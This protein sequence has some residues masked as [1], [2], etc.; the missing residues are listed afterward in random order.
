MARI[1]CTLAVALC[2]TTASAQQWA[3]KMFSEKDVDF[4]AVPRAAKIE[5]D[6]IVTNPYNEEVHIAHVRS[7]CGC[8]QPRIEHDTLKPGEQGKIVAAFNTRA[9]T[10]Q[11]GATVTVTFDRPQWSEVQL[12]VKGYIRTDVVLNPTYV[13]FGS[14]AQGAEG[15]K[16]VRIA[17]AGRS[18]WKITG[19]KSDSPYVTATVNET[20]REGGRVHYELDVKLADD[21]PKGYLKDQLILLTNDRRATQFPVNVE[22]RIVPELTVSPAQLMLGSLQPGKKITKQIVVKGAQPFK[23]VDIRCDQQGFTFRPQDESKTVHLV[24]VTFEVPNTPGKVSCNIEIV[25]DTDD[26]KTITLPVT[27]EI[28]A[29]WRVTDRGRVSGGGRAPPGGPLN[30]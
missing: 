21:A 12:H 9:F 17:Y 4:G 27:G 15:D 2:A 11:R 24:P 20:G 14:V 23:I 26:Q 1:I 7:S 13:N 10:G 6:F 30:R 22:G 28:G 19:V 3:D 8:T 18:D 5:H 16:K 29:P 25:T